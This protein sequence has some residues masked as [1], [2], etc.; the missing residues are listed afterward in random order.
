VGGNKKLG[1]KS[2]LA[3]DWCIYT[4]PKDSTTLTQFT[5]FPNDRPA[6]TVITAT[7]Q[8]TLFIIAVNQPP[9]VAATTTSYSVVIPPKGSTTVVINN[10]TVADPDVDLNFMTVNITLTGPGFISIFIYYL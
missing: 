9:T 4:P 8:M 3:S 10:I 5:Y 2:V 7:D 6:S 1:R